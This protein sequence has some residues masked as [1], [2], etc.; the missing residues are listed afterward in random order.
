MR[1]NPSVTLLASGTFTNFTSNFNTTQSGP[2][3]NEWNQ[4]TGW[5]LL[6][7][8]SNWSST[9]VVIPSWEGYSLEF[10]SDL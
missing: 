8:S 4:S 9:S 3:V 6:Y 1:I 2:T 10:S 7:A 5:G